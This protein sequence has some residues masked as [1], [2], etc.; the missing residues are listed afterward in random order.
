MHCEQ[1]YFVPVTTAIGRFPSHRADL[2]GFW[3]HEPWGLPMPAANMSIQSFQR[4]VYA[5][6]IT[7]RRRL[8]WRRVGDPYAILVSEVMLQQT[9][10]DRVIPKFHAFMKRFPDAQTLARASLRQ[11]LGVWSGLGYN[12]RALHLKQAAQMLVR[13][14]AGQVPADRETLMQLPGVGTYTAGAVLAFGFNV[15]SVFIETNIRTVFLHHFFSQRR[16]VHDREILKLVEQTM[17]RKN[18]RRWYSALMDYGA[19]LKTSGVRINE[20]STT[21]HRAGRF[22][23][24]HREMRGRIVRLL[25][26]RG[27]CFVRDICG[28]LKVSKPRIQACVRK[29]AREGLLTIRGELIRV[30]Q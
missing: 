14:F 19:G 30:A 5:E 17:D 21:Y 16:R 26:R 22:R 23:G 7:H 2:F 13:E 18:P 11:V 10:V 15:P 3:T 6:F 24:S 12:R 4:L 27:A 8:P 1:S 29:L 28:D 20:R 25:T 9:Q